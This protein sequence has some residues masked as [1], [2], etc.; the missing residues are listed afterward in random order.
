M[1][2]DFLAL[3]GAFALAFLL[4]TRVDARPLAEQTSG[5]TFLALFAL[6]IPLWL[7]VFAMFGLYSK[8][9]YNSRLSEAARLLVG[10]AIGVMVIIT[11]DFFTIETIFPA[12]LIPIYGFALGFALLLIGRVVNRYLKQLLKTRGVGVERV[13]IVGTSDETKDI[14]RL[15]SE[16]PR[17]EYIIL[18]VV[19]AKTMT[20]EVEVPQFR[21]VKEALEALGTDTI[22]SIIQTKLY[23]AAAKNRELLELAHQNHMT[24]TFLPTDQELY[25]GR[26]TVELF[27]G[28]P[29]VQVHPTPLVGWGRVVKRLF[30]FAVSL[31][32]VIVLSPIM[33]LV[34]ILIL[35]TDPG[36]IIFKQKRLTRFGNEVT[37]LKFRTMKKKYSG[38]P[39]REVFTELGRDD[40]LEKLKISDAQIEN[41]PRVSWIGKFLR[42][43]SLDELPQLFNVLSGSLSLVGPRAIIP[44]EF[45]LYEDKGWSLLNVKA[46]ITGLAQVSG[47]SDL[48]YSERWE[49]NIYYVQNWSFWL[50]IKILLKTI[51]ALLTKSDAR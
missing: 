35:C 22:T 44:E 1:I 19:G 15:L 24:Y 43:T 10:S 41:D 40:L 28:L 26:N 29:M 11:Y 7:L 13:L 25:A 9:V 37:V 21:S 16:H 45:R 6:V 14:L 5:R 33:V 38:R 12:K 4:R 32:A 42:A 31:C 2:G 39:P 36:K 49:L 51:P 3:I 34:A 17:S 8:Y 50:D 48:S 47:R 20:A 27:E 23:D 46:G 18:G 30:D